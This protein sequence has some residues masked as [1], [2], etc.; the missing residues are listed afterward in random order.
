MDSGPTHLSLLASNVYLSLLLSR[1]SPVFT[2][3]TPLAFLSLLRSVRRSTKNSPSGQPRPLDS[4]QGHHVAAKRKRNRGS[5]K[6]TRSSHSE[7]CEGEESEFDARALFSVLQRLQLVM[8]LIHLDR[9]PDSLKSLVQTV[10]EIPV[11]TFELCGNSGT[12]DKLVNFC[13]LILRDVLRPEHGDP[14]NSAAEVL[15]SLSSMILHLKSH[16]RAFALGFVTNQMVDVAKESHGVKKAL[17]NLPKY[18][19]QKAPEKSEP[20]ALAVESIMKIVQVMEFQDQN[21]FVE[22]VLKMSQGKANL[23]LLAV[24][25]IL[26]LVTT[27]K[28]PLGLSLEKEVKYSW[29]M[30]CLEA[31]IQRCSDVIAGTRARALLNLSQ[32]VGFWSSD[33]NGQAVLKQVLGFSD[34]GEVR[35]DDLLRNRCTDEKAAVRK[36]A[37]LLVAKLTAL[38]DSSF[39][40]S[41]LKAM[42]MACSDPLVS[43]RK[44]AISAISEVPF[45]WHFYSILFPLTCVIFANWFK[46]IVHGFL[47]T[48]SYV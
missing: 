37:L 41:L 32:L 42:G 17:V 3:F 11:T 8:G 26:M 10:A 15:K 25:L 43:I 2:L 12:Y 40:G 47:S 7:D 5:K 29:G 19:A 23:R 18:L 22:Y 48:S 6:G 14:A 21:L 45:L 16:V 24:D 39:D 4:S 44:A 27:L 30:R 36:A 1:N 38:F 34:V 28:D 31:L 33:E 35:V 13:S 9:F 20:R 46:I